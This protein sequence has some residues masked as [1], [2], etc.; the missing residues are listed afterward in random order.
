MDLRNRIVAV[1]DDSTS[2]SQTME[3][4]GAMGIP[5]DTVTVLSGPDGIWRLDAD[6]GHSGPLARI[7]RILQRINVEGEHL[8]RY[9]AEMGDGHAVV[10]VSIRDTTPRQDVIAV[11]RS[12]GG[13]FVN[14]YDEWIIEQIAA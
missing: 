11:L 14:A 8:R 1:L 13:H 5:D 7:V 3:A 9:Q 10:D 6:G 2:V 12:H 4:L